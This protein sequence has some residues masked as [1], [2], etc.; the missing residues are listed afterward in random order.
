MS[1]GIGTYSGEVKRRGGAGRKPDAS[2]IELQEAILDS[3]KTGKPKVWPKGASDFKK[4]A[5]KVRQTAFNMKST[6]RP[7]GYGVSVNWDGT[8]LT[9]LA[10]EKKAKDAAPAPAPTPEP[11]K[12]APPAKKATA[13]KAPAKKA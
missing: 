4:N 10:Y 11:P 9:F 1:L 3:V 12:P 13:K 5:S 7:T 6:D 2:T 8:D